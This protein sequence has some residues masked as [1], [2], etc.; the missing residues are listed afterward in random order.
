MIFELWY[1]TRTKAFETNKFSYQV[2]RF[3]SELNTI[4]MCGKYLQEGKI[5]KNKAILRLKGVLNKIFIDSVTT[6]IKLLLVST[7]PVIL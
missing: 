6:V 2:T 7:T 1:W 3:K 4:Q 5:Y